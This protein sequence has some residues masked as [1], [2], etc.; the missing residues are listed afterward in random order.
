MVNEWLVEDDEI[1][2]T[3]KLLPV[4]NEKRDQIPAVNQAQGFR[5][6]QTDHKIKIRRYHM[7][8]SQLYKITDVAT[9]LNTFF[10]KNEPLVCV[11]SE[12][13]EYF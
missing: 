10:I 1:L 4:K 6:L 12:T 11:S 8:I 3:M 7:L 9:L 13:L 5:R 2:V